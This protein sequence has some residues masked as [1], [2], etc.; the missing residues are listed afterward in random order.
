M[1]KREFAI[2]ADAMKTYYPKE[3]NLLPNDRALELWFDQLSD[4]PY[5][6]ATIGLRKWV[7]ISEWSPSIADVR[8]MASE[9]TRP[10]VKSW[11]EAWE[12]V[13]R[14]IQRYGH[15]DPKGAFAMM[16]DITKKVVR[17]IG[18]MNLCMSENQAAD[19]ANFRTM[20]EREAERQA[21]DAQLPTS[22][23]ELIGKMQVGAI[24]KKEAEA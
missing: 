14:S 8:R 20:Y 18:Y 2:F 23:R 15:V 9:V 17:Q 7:A 22:L 4:I 6:V 3:K 24:E 11:G 16:D 1:D 19:R 10:K 21:Q 5:D 12:D 13:I